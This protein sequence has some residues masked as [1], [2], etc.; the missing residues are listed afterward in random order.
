MVATLA[1]IRLPIMGG[2]SEW[3]E[4]LLDPASFLTA[5]TLAGTALVLWPVNE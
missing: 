2:P 3:H 5:L 4:R 1:V